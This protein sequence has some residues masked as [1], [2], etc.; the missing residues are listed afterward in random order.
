MAGRG[1]MDGLFFIASKTLGM[2]SRLESWALLVLALSCLALWRGRVRVAGAG[3]G[4]LF[5]A[6]LAL[7]VFPLGDL[8]LR[9]L[10]A[11][12]PAAPAVER[13]DGI[14]VLGGAEETGAHR[15]WGGYQ[16][17]EAGER[18]VE[19]A[20]LAHRFPAARLVF[21]G[22]TAR[23]GGVEDTTDPSVM[24]RDLWI[25]LG[26]APERIVL[27]QESR[28]TAENAAMAREM[29]RPAAGETWVL[30]TSAFHMPRAVEVF[31]RQGWDGIV[32]WPVDFRSGDLADGRGIWRFDRNLSG[33]NVALKEYL[34]TLAYRMVGK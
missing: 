27:E 20:V 17:N 6:T 19:A 23:V 31:R 22:G 32:P 21:T 11:Q 4:L 26:I 33:V 1:L 8:L 25:G 12:Y 30:V 10:E 3:L 34:G 13:V 5:A 7:T 16:A 14:I 29:V 15:L 18:L 28:N 9:P 24:A 2:A